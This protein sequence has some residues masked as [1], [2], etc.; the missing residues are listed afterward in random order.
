MMPAD[1]VVELK[2]KGK[3]LLT[4]EL[5][6]EEVKEEEKTEE[7]LVDGTAETPVLTVE[8]MKAKLDEA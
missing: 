2:M 5:N 8:E 6:V 4:D 3:V 7:V 1:K